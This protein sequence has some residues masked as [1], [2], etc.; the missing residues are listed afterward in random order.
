MPVEPLPA[1]KSSQPRCL[2]R[3]AVVW[4]DDLEF[5]IESAEVYQ[6]HHIIEADRCPARFPSRDRG[7]GSVGKG[8]QLRLGE[9]CASAGLPDQL[10]TESHPQRIY[11]LC[12][13]GDPQL[14]GTRF[15]AHTSL[16]ADTMSWV[17]TRSR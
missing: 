7:L 1:G 13:T 3:V 11:Q 10:R 6:A 14:M 16:T 5:Q 8:R 12:Y 9:A 4:L 15:S 2:G 17:R